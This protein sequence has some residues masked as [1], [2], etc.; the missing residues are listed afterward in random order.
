MK[1]RIVLFGAGKFGIAAYNTLKD[2]HEIICF[3][4]NKK[5][6]QGKELLGVPIVSPEKMISMIDDETDIVISSYYYLE[7]GEQLEGL[8]INDYYI[9]LDGTIFPKPEKDANRVFR[10]CTRCIMDNKSDDTIMFDDEGRCSYCTSAINNI[11]KVY[12]PNETGEKMLTQMISK[13]KKYGEDKIYDCIMGLSGG[14]DSSYLVYLGYKWGLNVL[15]VHVDDGFDTEISKSNISKL[16][17]KT[18]F[19]YESI[20]L[21]S[22]QYADLVVSYMRAGVPNIAV[23]QD[24][25]DLAFIY[26][27]LRHYNI[28]YFLSGG[29]FAL[30]CILQRGNTY[31]N[32]D[33]QNI[34]NIHKI[35][36]K[37][38]IGK[39]K[40]ISSEE[41]DELKD[42]LGLD[43]LRPLDLIDYNKDRA[44]KELANFC[45]FEYYGRKHLE[46]TLTAFIQ[47][48]WFPRKFNVDKRT[49]HL[50]SL[51]VS[52]Q[53][54]RQEALEKMKEPLYEEKEM[55]KCIEI[56]K[57]GLNID[58]EEF[59][60]LMKADV[61]KHEEYN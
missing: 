61:H 42:S 25:C 1:K 5:T 30:E 23:P 46:N 55:E 18:G 26:D 7:I 6:L 14:L 54:T 9:G 57:K 16:I 15:V 51:I 17:K 60:K 13:L 12:L 36:G 4:D 22:E 37:K 32:L 40:F 27:R 29:N 24:N 58:D 10:R 52:G 20:K 21:D 56:V 11:G 44:F 53:M 43:T 19:D 33:V 50:S 38:D 41:V 3:C 2:T 34:Y 31:S 28:K 8:N 47:L 59:E 39:L 45:D 49:S 35:F 48:Y